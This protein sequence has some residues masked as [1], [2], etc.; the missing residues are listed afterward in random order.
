MKDHYFARVQ[1]Q[2]NTRWWVN[3]P[4]PAETALALEH[5]V[6]A[7]T[8]NPTFAANL[9]RRDRE[10]ALGVVAACRRESNDVCVVADL[11]QQRLV[12]RVMGAFRPVYDKSGGRAGWVSIQGD[13]YAEVDAHHIVGEAR[14]YRKLGPNF[15]AKIPTTAAGLAAME[16]LLGEGVPVIATEV[17][18]LP[19]MIALGEMYQRAKQKPALYV[20]HITGIFDEYLQQECVGP[21]GITIAPAVLAQAGLAVARRQYREFKRRG[22]GGTLLGGGAREL[23]HFTGLVGGDWHVTI[24]WKDAAAL[25]KQNP[26]VDRAFEAE[27]PAAVIAELCEKLPDFRQAWDEN[28]LAIGEFA[29]YGPVQRFR[30][31]FIHGWDE[32]LAA[33]RG[34]SK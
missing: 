19:Q 4:T 17:F 13:P 6:F 24:N 33:I 31:Q 34:D 14:R 11:V 2:T 8:T 1:Q 28:G 16:T 26:P 23:K 29:H 5:D 21:L 18:G 10:F 12:A 30:R 7:C 25:L 27:T 20:T 15:I 22:Y 9:L 3:N 32:L